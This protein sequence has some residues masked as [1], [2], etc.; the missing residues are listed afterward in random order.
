MGLWDYLRGVGN[1]VIGRTTS[2]MMLEAPRRETDSQTHYDLL[3]VRAQNDDVYEEVANALKDTGQIPDGY[4]AIKSLR[5]HI[6]RVVDVYAANLLQDDLLDFLET[7]E[8]STNSVEPLRPLIS[9]IWQWS[10]WEE[11]LK[12]AFPT[13]GTY[14]LK[15]ASSE[16][17]TRVYPQILDPRHCV[18][19]EE[20]ERKYLTYLRVQ[21]PQERR[22]LATGEIENFTSVEVWSKEGLFYRVWHVEEDDDPGAD[23]EK[24][25]V[26]LIDLILDVV[27]PGVV[28]AT[29][30][31]GFDFIPVVHRPFK[32]IFGKKRGVTPYE[33]ALP[34]IDRINELVTKLHEML[35][36]EVVWFLI[37]PP[38]PESTPIAPIKIAGEAQPA[39]LSEA[40][41]QGFKVVKTPVGKIMRAPGGSQLDPKIPAIDFASHLSVIQDEASVIE[42][43][44]IELAYYRIRELQLS[45][46]AIDLALRDLVDRIK[47]ARQNMERG[48]VQFNQM[49]ITIA[50]VLEIP[51]FLSVGTFED[52]ALDHTFADRP[53]FP[54]VDA[55]NEAQ[56]NPDGTPEELDVEPDAPGADSTGRAAQILADRFNRGGNNGQA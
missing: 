40:E 18:D 2:A 29:R 17:G 9:T 33:H 22:D 5:N 1:A 56:L 37:P 32:R 10:E 4:A 36:P 48:L 28:D 50:Q 46:I 30:Y 14:W 3:Q 39:D 26:P 25:G 23:L 13:Y 45:G 35:F 8:G 52:G 54:S 34:N 20:N 19:W 47:S 12:R 55:D 11:E 51:E 27:P 41:R 53:V 16:D 7:P 42:E 43:M 15:A 24:L 49:A 44:L 38:G 21:I 6:P 31:T